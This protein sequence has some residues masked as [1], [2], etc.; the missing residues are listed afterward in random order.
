MAKLT[1]E[2]DHNGNEPWEDKRPGGLEC[3]VHEDGLVGQILTSEQ[4]SQRCRTDGRSRHDP[5]A[6]TDALED[7]RRGFKVGPGREPMDSRGVK[8][9]LDLVARAGSGQVERACF[10]NAVAT[11]GCSSPPGGR[12][13]GQISPPRSKKTSSGASSHPASEQRI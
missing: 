1:A 6:Q 13:G 8:H 3:G 12:I 11:N 5:S 9:R 7:V 10:I 2:L 4:E